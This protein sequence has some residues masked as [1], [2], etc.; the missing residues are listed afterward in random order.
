MRCALCLCPSAAWPLP[1]L[2]HHDGCALL[3]VGLC[4]QEGQSALWMGAG[5]AV[6][7]PDKVG[8]GGLQGVGAP[9]SS[10]FPAHCQPL[11]MAA[12]PAGRGGRG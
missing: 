5:A 10:R 2:L 11:C 1:P 6:D 9:F 7:Q 3:L 4:M 8:E 12:S